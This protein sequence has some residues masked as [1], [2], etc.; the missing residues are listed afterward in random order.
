[1]NTENLTKLIRTKSAA[2]FELPKYFG[3][4]DIDDFISVYNP[5]DYDEVPHVPNK[6][7]EKNLYKGKFRRGKKISLEEKLKRFVDNIRPVK[8]TKKKMDSYLKDLLYWKPPTKIKI[9]E[10]KPI[11]PSE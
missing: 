3:K 4:V 8:K 9:E 7:I 10:K 6:K 2:Q 11:P 1:M 5:D